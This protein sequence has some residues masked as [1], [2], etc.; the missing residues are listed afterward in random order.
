VL[1]GTVTEADG[2]VFGAD[3]GLGDA[4][5]ADLG[6]GFVVTASLEHVSIRY[7]ARGD[8]VTASVEEVL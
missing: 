4:V 6:D 1:R 8:S 3:W 5:L 7:D 2:F